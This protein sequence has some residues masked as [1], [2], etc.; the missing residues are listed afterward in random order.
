MKRILGVAGV[1]ALLLFVVAPA[2]AF[3]D[4]GPISGGTKA[5]RRVSARPA[6]ESIPRRTQADSC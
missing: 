6:T 3:A 5:S 1:G 2:V 4:N